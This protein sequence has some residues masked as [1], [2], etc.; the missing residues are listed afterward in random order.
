MSAKTK[1]ETGS[2]VK[3]SFETIKNKGL[4]INDL[5]ADEPANNTPE[6]Q[7]NSSGA[8]SNEPE[9]G[10]IQYP[11]QQFDP[12]G[13]PKPAGHQTVT[14]DA[15]DFELAVLTYLASE[16]VRDTSMRKEARRLIRPMIVEMAKRIE[17]EGEHM[18]FKKIDVN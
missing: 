15:N 1:T 13:K 10:A 16:D 12:E 9:S 4:N 3:R 8:E 2:G 5:L 6:E 7:L 18:A 14:F 17:A 11:W